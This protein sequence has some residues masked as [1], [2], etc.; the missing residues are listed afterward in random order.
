MDFLLERASVFFVGLVLAQVCI[1][2]HQVI[3]HF[4]QD[5]TVSVEG[6]LGIRAPNAIERVVEDHRA[7]AVDLAWLVADVVDAVKPEAEGT[8]RLYFASGSVLS[9]YDSSKHYE[10]F[11][12]SHGTDLYVV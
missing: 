3:L 10:S 6:D 1:G 12:V 2:R 9:F 7:A 11:Q 5:A 8:L 4:D